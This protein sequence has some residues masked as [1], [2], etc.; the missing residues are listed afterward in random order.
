MRRLQHI[1]CLLLSVFWALAPVWQA[2]GLAYAK[3]KA[4]KA[5]K[6]TAKVLHAEWIF[7]SSAEYQNVKG[8]HEFDFHGERY[9]LLSIKKTDRGFLLKVIN[10]KLEKA[11]K[12]WGETHAQSNSAEKNKSLKWSDK[13][14]INETFFVHFQRFTTPSRSLTFPY[15]SQLSS[16]F[17]PELIKPPCA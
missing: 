3:Y 13:K 10:D 8:L 15:T 1:S 4:G 7:L 5:A 12:I 2:S 16:G 17:A 9:D 14:D 6:Q 11:F